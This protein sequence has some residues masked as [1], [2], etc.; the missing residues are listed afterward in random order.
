MKQRIVFPLL[1]TL[2]L[3]VICGPAQ[4]A[5]FTIPAP[6]DF[7]YVNETTLIP[8][9]QPSCTNTGN[10]GDECPAA[11]IITALS[12]G[13][14]TV[15]FSSP[16][17][18]N[19][20]V[21]REPVPVG[22]A[23]WNDPPAVETSTP[24]VAQNL[25][26]LTCATCTLT[27]SFSMPVRTFGFE[28]EPDP[29]PSGHVITATFF[30][31]ATTVGAITIPF[32]T[33]FGSARLFAATTDEQFTRVNVSVTGT[34]FAIAQLRFSTE[35]LSAIPEPGSVALVLAGLAALVGARRF[36]RR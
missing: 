21:S 33:G 27:M 28:A 15:N 9:T 18:Q 26:D 23:T 2:L 10:P 36:R 11:T 20:L 17:V 29:F 22:W 25:V 14:L 19:L 13:G 34:D 35:T 32:P 8:I 6:G 3:L 7:N 31:G 16:E 30:N 1:T 12:A 5:F 24:K 4:A